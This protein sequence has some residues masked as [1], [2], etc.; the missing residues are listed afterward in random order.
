MLY[1]TTNTAPVAMSALRARSRATRVASTFGRATVQ[2]VPGAIGAL[3]I[4][5]AIDG[6]EIEVTNPFSRAVS[7]MVECTLP[8]VLVERGWSMQ[9]TSYGASSFVVPSWCSR[10]V[11]LTLTPGRQIWP[12]AIAEA[13]SR[14]IVVSIGS[15]RR[16][17]QVEI[18]RLD[19]DRVA[20]DRQPRASAAAASDGRQ[21]FVA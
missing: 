8:A 2:P 19:P 14:D 7:V 6:L 18:F 3:G 13:D 9:A 17:L 12:A 10:P 1:T 21:D 16:I 11:R 15:E 5:D 20:A 4:V